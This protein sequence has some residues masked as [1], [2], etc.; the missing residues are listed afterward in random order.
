MEKIIMQSAALQ[1][2]RAKSLASAETT[3]LTRRLL[4][5]GVA[6][7]PVYMV[8]GLAQALTREGF[9]MTRHALSLLS[10][11]SL[12]WIQISNFLVSG[13]LVIAC[14]VGV[15]KALHPGRA[16]TWGPLLLAGYGL[17]LIGAG[18]FVAD[19]AL[20]FPPGT[21]ARPPHGGTL[22]GMMHFVCGGLGFYSLIAACFVFARRFASLKQPGWTW[23]SVITG[24]F[25][26]A[27]FSGIA[28]GS[29]QAWIIITFW[30]GVLALWV[31]L[32][33]VAARLMREI[34]S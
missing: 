24:L 19:P 14:A 15:W 3:M 27:A 28:S 23:Y 26:F 10:N 9:D 4:A 22:H 1:G 29:H 30:F 20:G 21:P 18:V 12:G 8:V 11:G 16:G 33:A 34:S 2:D 32:S 13:A 17:G 25:F 5:C 6:A 7:G 31:W